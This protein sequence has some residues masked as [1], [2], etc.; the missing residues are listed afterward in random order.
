[1]QQAGG[2]LLK[3]EMVP[4]LFNVFATRYAERP[5][6]YT[7]IHKYGSRRG[8]NAPHAILELVDNPND[9]KYEMAA[10]TVGFE[11]YGR[12]A[13]KLPQPI[14]VQDATAVAKLAEEQRDFEPSTARENPSPLRDLTRLN[15][16][17]ALRYRS[18]AEVAEFG[19]KARDH[20]VSSI[21]CLHQGL[22]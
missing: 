17:K 15:I 6:G 7:R 8:D 19:T 11:L 16:K 4:K 3:P 10:R 12:L 13:R 18:K 2:F 22:R 14:N 20:V 5:G 21:R 9:L 1:M